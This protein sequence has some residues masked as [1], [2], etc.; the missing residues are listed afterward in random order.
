VIDSYIDAHKK[1]QRFVQGYETRERENQQHLNREQTMGNPPKQYY[2]QSPGVSSSKQF[3]R[4]TPELAPNWG[5]Y[6]NTTPTVD[7]KA[8]RSKQ[9]KG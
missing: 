8:P 1:A 2:D 4:R 9:I 3:L 6:K 7:P 5:D